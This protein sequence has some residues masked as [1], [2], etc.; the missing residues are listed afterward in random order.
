MDNLSQEKFN[1][2]IRTYGSNICENKLRC[3]GLLKDT[4]PEHPRQVSLLISAL[5]HGIPQ[6]LLSS[7]HAIP[8]AI[9]RTRLIKKLVSNLYVQYR[10][11]AW[12]VDAWSIALGMP[13]PEAESS[14]SSSTAVD[15]ASELTPAF[16][17]TE[18]VPLADI[19]RVLSEQK[20]L[21][22]KRESTSASSQSQPALQT[23]S[24]QLSQTPATQIVSPDSSSGL[25]ATQI[26]P[27]SRSTVAPILPLQSELPE[28]QA[29]TKSRL[30]IPLVG[31]LLLLLSFGAG[32][33]V[34]RLFS[35]PTS[36]QATA[37]I[38]GSGTNFTAI[39][40]V[41]SATINYG[42]STTWAQVR[43]IVD[44]EIARAFPNYRLRYVDPLGEKPGS[45]TG[46]KMLLEGQLSMAQSSR[47][48]KDE[49]FQRA[50]MRGLKLEQIPI[51]LDAIVAVT[52]P[53]LTI[54]GL[55]VDQLKH[56]Y[57]GKI[58]NWQQVG[59]PNLAITP[60]SRDLKAGGTVDFFREQVLGKDV[61][62]GRAVQ[63]VQDTTSGLRRTAR[64]PGSIYYGSAPEV[65]DQCTVKAIPIAKVAG[66]WV[67]PYQE[68]FVPLA[69]CP[70]RRNLVNQTAIRNGSYPLTRSLFVV[71]L[72]NGQT[73]EKAG[74]AY[75]N[76]LLT[77]QGQKLLNQA[78]FVS[79]K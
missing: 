38:D 28:P 75:A 68:P 22:A 40:G 3:E 50:Q 15:S 52:H 72:Q 49:E 30:M 63:I 51:A 13:V 76:L 10:A 78:G 46:I 14:M 47:P 74:R 21:Q 70:G 24:T 61:A 67:T 36:P 43:K 23:N 19:Q 8:S 60:I 41:P 45:G 77:D 71:L 59:G 12:A 17:N 66:Q 56:I 35:A 39:Q 42:G 5:N 64:T 32:W 65:V 62:F 11:A 18:Q 4:F 37:S 29:Q 27:N 54:P 2:L 9:T 34:W 20:S 57:T 69:E 79:L 16:S 26:R 73:E 53:D 55:T 33:S 31:G 44:P 6:E 25:E 58:T 7:Q 1:Q 48:L